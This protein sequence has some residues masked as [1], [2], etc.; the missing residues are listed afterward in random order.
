MREIDVDPPTLTAA[1]AA[2][3]DARQRLSAIADRAR[4]LADDPMTGS[5]PAADEGVHGAQMWQRARN[6]FAEG[7]ATMTAA[8]DRLQAGLATSATGYQDAD[9]TADAHMKAAGRELGL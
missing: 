7:L 2:V 3:D 8:L 9:Q 5:F 4:Q 1:A 6:T